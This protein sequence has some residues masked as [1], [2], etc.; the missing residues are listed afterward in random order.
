[1]LLHDLLDDLL[2]QDVGVESVG[3]VWFQVLDEFDE[4]FFGESVEY[5]VDFDLYFLHLSEDVCVVEQ[6]IVLGSFDEVVLHDFGFETD[7]L[8]EGDVHA[9]GFGLWRFHP[10]P[11]QFEFVC[12][13]FWFC[14]IGLAGWLV[15]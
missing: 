14:L 10:F 3:G 5:E 4:V 7:V 1:V 13:V 8:S 12:L 15:D 9:V 6:F 11:F 2:R